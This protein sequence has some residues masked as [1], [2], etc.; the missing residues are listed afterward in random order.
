MIYK[1]QT[2]IT[3]IPKVAEFFHIREYNQRA[4]LVGG[5]TNYDNTALRS[6]DPPPHGPVVELV[7]NGKPLNAK[8]AAILRQSQKQ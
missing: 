3:E 4:R 5:P 2:R 6:E 7:K 1:R 8:G